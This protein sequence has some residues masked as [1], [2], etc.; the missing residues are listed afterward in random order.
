[1]PRKSETPTCRRNL[2]CCS[3][4]A[5]RQILKKKIRE[6]SPKKGGGKFPGAL[7]SFPVKKGGNLRGAK[8]GR[9]GERRL[10]K[11]SLSPE[12][13]KIQSSP[14]KLSAGG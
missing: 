14:E 6:K 12:R 3:Q 11:G 7:K 1:L 13:K 4:T 9:R 8:K 2:F 5:A 10:K